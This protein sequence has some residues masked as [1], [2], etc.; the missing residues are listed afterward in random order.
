MKYKINGGAR[1][2]GIVRISGA[3]N[4]AL[5]IIAASMLGESPSVLHDVP[6][7]SDTSDMCELVEHMGAIFT[8]AADNSLSIYLEKSKNFIAPYDVVSK[9]R[10]S[11]LIMSP[12]L[13]RFGKVRI[14]LPGGCPIGTRPVDLHLK[15]FA[16]MGAKITQ[17]HGFVEARARKLVGAKVYLDFPSVGATENIMIAAALADGSTVIE[18]AAIEP[19]IVDLANFLN[20]MGANV[21]GAGSGTI[22]IM[23]V[24]RL[25]GAQHTIIPDRI[26]AG[27]FMTA[28]AMTRGEILLEN[29]SRD[30]LKPVIS[31]LSDVGIIIEAGENSILVKGDEKLKPSDIKTLPYPGFPTDMQ[32]Q[33]TAFMSNVEGT[34][35]VVE[36]VFENRF[37]HAAELARMGANIKVDGR[38]A[39]IEGK[40]KLSGAQVKAT[41]LRAGAALTLAA[42]VCDDVSEISDVHHID[43][44]YENF[45]LKLRSL[46]AVI[47]KTTDS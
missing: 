39:I 20:K 10:A 25:C 41:D 17:G 46:G 47:E 8:R 24:K 43:R 16:A 4:A 22:R 28:A 29:V 12:M 3:K 32:A 27:T 18:N 7:V 1:L 35:M 42:L 11:F 30:H 36:T 6:K 9:F 14:P 5:P 37:L 19:E 2:C 34:S 33:F 23:G 45:E 13:A 26:E 15:G 21:R 38:C 31:K 40:K 44:G